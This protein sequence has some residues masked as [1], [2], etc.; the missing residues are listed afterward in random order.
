MCFS[1]IVWYNRK[2]TSHLESFL[3]SVAGLVT[4]FNHLSL[5]S[6]VRLKKTRKFTKQTWKFLY[7]RLR[8]TNDLSLERFLESPFGHLLLEKFSSHWQHDKEW[9]IYPQH[10]QCSHQS[11]KTSSPN[12]SHLEILESY[13]WEDCKNTWDKWVLQDLKDFSKPYFRIHVWAS[14]WQSQIN[15][16]WV[17]QSFI[18]F[19]IY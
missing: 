6:S 10:I 12:M 14:F 2:K 8:L 19:G 13:F 18:N 3:Y 11:S 4:A 1:L 7:P 9:H 16:F 17:W 5:A 15:R